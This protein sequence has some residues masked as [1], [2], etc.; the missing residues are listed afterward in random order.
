MLT[1]TY[2]NSS[3]ATCGWL[4]DNHLMYSIKHDNVKIHNSWSNVLMFDL[5][6]TTEKD[7]PK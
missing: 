4:K 5:V 6:Q 1:S 3:I 2:T 7:M